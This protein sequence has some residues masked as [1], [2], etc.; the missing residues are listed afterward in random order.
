MLSRLFLYTADLVYHA[1]A[2]RLADTLRQVQ[3]QTC[4]LTSYFSFRRGHQGSKVLA[5]DAALLFTS[6]S[7]VETVDSVCFFIDTERISIENATEGLKDKLPKDALC[8]VSNRVT[9][10]FF[11]YGYLHGQT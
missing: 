5:T 9:A 1:I 2:V 4:K 6:T 11:L 3:E 7:R 8:V 10:W